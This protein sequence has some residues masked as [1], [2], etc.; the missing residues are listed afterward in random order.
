M[1]LYFSPLTCSLATRIALYE[2]GAAARFIAVDTKAQR[3]EDGVDYASINPLGLVPVLRTAGGTLLTEN[4]AVLQYIADSYPE[5]RLAPTDLEGRAQ[6]HQW[7]SFISS[8]LH[9]GI[10]SL[11]FSRETTDP[12]KEYAR[13]KIA[14]RF[15][16]LDAHLADREYLLGAFSVADAY[17]GTVLNWTRVAGPDL[18]DWPSLNAYHKRVRARPAVARAQAEEFALY[19]AEQQR[20]A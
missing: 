17:L 7:L 20:S 8:E 19:T 1:E 4:C 11:Q 2:V 16:R 18:R 14:S 10:Y 13:K 12:V 6:L 15:G 5:A 3:T 9:K